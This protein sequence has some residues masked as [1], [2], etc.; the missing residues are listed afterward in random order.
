MRKY[1]KVKEINCI[2]MSAFI[3]DIV[4]IFLFLI[5]YLHLNIGLHPDQIRRCT[6]TL[7]RRAA[8]EDHTT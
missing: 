6:E 2:K 7:Q 1:K 8:V 3:K 4:Q 5:C